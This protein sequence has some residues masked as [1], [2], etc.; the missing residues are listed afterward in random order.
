M[1]ADNEEEA[2]NSLLKSWLFERHWI[3]ITKERKWTKYK[4]L[5]SLDQ[6]N[7]KLQSLKITKKYLFESFKFA[8]YTCP[9][10]SFLNKF[11]TRKT[12]LLFWK[13]K[14]SIVMQI[15]QL[16]RLGW[17]AFSENFNSLLPLIASLQS[18]MTCDIPKLSLFSKS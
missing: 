4:V 3:Q 6:K 14:F 17:N 12:W 15:K 13:P 1:M 5:I 2:K 11:C 18:C 7:L 16:L 9:F 8:F 10:S